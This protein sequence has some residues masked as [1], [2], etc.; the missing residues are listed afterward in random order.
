[1]SALFFFAANPPSLLPPFHAGENGLLPPSKKAPC[2]QLC[3]TPGRPETAPPSPCT[4]EPFL[5][6]A[7]TPLEAAAVDGNRD[8][9]NLV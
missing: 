1:M 9:R 8:L 6:P 3:L 4:K 2:P 7:N 5:Q